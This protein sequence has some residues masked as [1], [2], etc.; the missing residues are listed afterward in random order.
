MIQRSLRYSEQTQQYVRKSIKR[1]AKQLDSRPITCC[2][3]YIHPVNI[4]SCIKAK[5]LSLIQQKLDVPLQL[6]PDE[7]RIL[8]VLR[9]ISST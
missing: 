2:K 1:I 8:L 3:Y 5:L 9:Q 4:E 7:Q 6:L